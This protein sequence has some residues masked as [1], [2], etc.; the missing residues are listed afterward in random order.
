MKCNFQCQKWSAR[1]YNIN[2]SNI[3]ELVLF[4]T[5]TIRN[6][7]ILNLTDTLKISRGF[8]GNNIH[9]YIHPYIDPNHSFYSTTSEVQLIIKS[10]NYNHDNGKFVFSF[11]INLRLILVSGKTK[12]FLFLPNDSAADIT[13]HVYTNWPTGMYIFI[14]LYMYTITWTL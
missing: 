10:S 11:Q 2:M 7:W 4:A 9:L 13:D 14:E 12:E 6:D 1:H 5:Q 3:G 8:L